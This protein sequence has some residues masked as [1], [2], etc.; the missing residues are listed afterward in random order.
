[1]AAILDLRSAWFLAIFD[2]QVTKCFLP[3]FESTGLSVQE[4]KWKI[5]FQD[6]CHGAHPGFTI[7]MILAIFD[8]QVTPMLP[9]KF[10]V[11]WPFSSGEE[12]KNRFSRWRPWRPSWISNRHDFSYFWSISHPN[13]SNKVWSQLAFGFRSRSEKY[14]FEMAAMAAILDF[15]LAWF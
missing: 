14:I 2:L 3:S 12:A 9:T 6:G 7:G 5:D 1:M 13:A 8:L 10:G 15:R 4:K 11:N